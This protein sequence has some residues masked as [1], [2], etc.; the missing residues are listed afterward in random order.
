MELVFKGLGSTATSLKK[1]IERKIPGY[2][3]NLR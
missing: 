1:K 3:A 2:T